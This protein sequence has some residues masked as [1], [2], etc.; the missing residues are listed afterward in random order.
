MVF[1]PVAMVRTALRA[2]RR[3]FFA[4]FAAGTA[5]FDTGLT[6]G[7]AL[8]GTGLAAG[9]ARVDTGLAAGWGLRAGAGFA[10]LL[11]PLRP[12]TWMGR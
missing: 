3:G 11:R 6:A 12:R 9:V 7:V 8:F 10:V 4:G 2:A 5:W 1:T